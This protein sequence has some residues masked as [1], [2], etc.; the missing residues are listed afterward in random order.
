MGVAEQSTTCLTIASP[1]VILRRLP[2][3]LSASLSSVLDFPNPSEIP[4]ASEQG[5]F[6]RL[7]QACRQ[8][9]TCALDP[10]RT[11]QRR[12]PNGQKFPGQSVNQIKMAKRK[13]P[14]SWENT[15][16]LKEFR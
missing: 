16:Q 10:D 3:S 1:L 4:C 14:A 8:R 15:V 5:I 9:R 12:T 13:I 2:F 7:P 6:C 11:W